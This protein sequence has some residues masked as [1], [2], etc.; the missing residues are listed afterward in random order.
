MKNI[1]LG[2]SVRLAAVDP[3]EMAKA[4]SHS[5]RDSE[6][7]RLMDSSAASLHSPK[8]FKEEIEKELEDP[9]SSTFYFSIRSCADNA[10]L[11]DIALDVDEWNTGNGFVGLAVYDRANWGKG[12]GSEAM[13]LLLEFAFNEVNLRRV[14]LTV[15]DYNPRA[16]RSYEKAG[17]RHEG[18]LRGRLM[19]EGKRW[20]MLVMGILREEWM[21]ING[22]QR[23]NG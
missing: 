11:G 8:A 16:I 17:F 12:F 1:L 13:H 18:R 20:D 14:S 3:E 22:S 9:D 6:L 5:V 10:L 21:A 23:M 4:A 7:D 2:K 19:R 15:F